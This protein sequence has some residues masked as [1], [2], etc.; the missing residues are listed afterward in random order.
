M[1]YFDYNQH[2]QTVGKTSMRE[3]S[4]KICVREHY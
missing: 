3:T 2:G 4:Y 1:F